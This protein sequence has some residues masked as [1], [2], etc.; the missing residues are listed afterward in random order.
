MNPTITSPDL[1]RQMVRLADMAR[2]APER[3]KRALGICIREVE[4]QA[5]RIATRA[6]VFKTGAGKLSQSLRGRVFSTTTAGLTVGVAYGL[7]QDHGGKTRPH[8]IRPRFAKAL[9]FPAG[10][11]Y[12]AMGLMIGKGANRQLLTGGRTGF[13]A[14]AAAKLHAKGQMQGM[15]LLKHVHHP[16]SRIPP[17]HYSWKAYLASRTYMQEQTRL[18]AMGRTA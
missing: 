15:M 14:G 6:G 16:G 3:R 8:I 11:G 9:M 18:A 5:K 13:Q 7:I 17:T 4:R 1:P 2:L 12:A 10:K